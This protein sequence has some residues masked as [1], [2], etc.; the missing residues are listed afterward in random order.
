MVV[1]EV[2]AVEVVA[3][4]DVGRAMYVAPCP[5][6]LAP[7][8]SVMGKH[9]KAEG[10]DMLGPKARRII[11]RSGWAWYNGTMWHPESPTISVSPAV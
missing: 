5:H 2:V 9:Q 11:W 3:K 1:V 7:T 8:P 10:W 4:E 6:A